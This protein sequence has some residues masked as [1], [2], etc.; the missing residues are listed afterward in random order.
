M[1]DLIGMPA[2][3]NDDHNNDDNEENNNANRYFRSYSHPYVY[4]HQRAFRLSLFM[5]VPHNGTF[6]ARPTARCE[7]T[8]V[9]Y[10]HEEA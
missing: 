2:G 6:T 3:D 9:R 7:N 10:T 4:C 1:K 8:A 5:N